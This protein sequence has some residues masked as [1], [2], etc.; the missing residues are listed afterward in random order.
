MKKIII[1]LIIIIILLLSVFI[2]LPFAIFNS[3][4]IKGSDSSFMEMRSQFD[5]LK[6]YSIPFS[7][8]EGGLRYN[9]IF[10]KGMDHYLVIRYIVTQEKLDK[11]RMDTSRNWSKTSHGIND[12]GIDWYYK[13]GRDD[14]LFYNVDRYNY[15]VLDLKNRFVYFVQFST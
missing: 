7:E 15:W 14:L 6:N 8:M 3:F 11:M 2:I 4:T 9:F 5:S 10:E 1:T 12:F 13:E